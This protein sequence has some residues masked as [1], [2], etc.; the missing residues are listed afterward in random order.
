MYFDGAS[1]KEG[2][3]ASIL[4]ISPIDEAVTLMYKLEFEATNYIIE[5]EAIVLG[6]RV[7]NYMKI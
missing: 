5:Y 1:S 3:G 6:L 4:L 2:P 7:A